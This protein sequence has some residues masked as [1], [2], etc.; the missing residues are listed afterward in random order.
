MQESHYDKKGNFFM[1]KFVI[2]EAIGKSKIK[3]GSML[4]RHVDLK[5]VLMKEYSDSFIV[6]EVEIG[7][8]KVRVMTRYGPQENWQ[9]D[10]REP[11]FEALESEVAC[12]ELES[13]SVI[14]SMDANS[15][16]G[17]QYIEGDPHVQTNNR[18]LLA[19]I[20]DSHALIVTNWLAGKRVGII[21]RE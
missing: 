11:F 15:K 21:T 1:D 13:R 10:E 17:A 5:P 20:L 7:T 12:A 4:G 16:Y 9:E 14:I 19:G 2:F 8:T 18:R 6:V 3:G